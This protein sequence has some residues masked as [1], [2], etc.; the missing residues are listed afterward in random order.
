MY[1]ENLITYFK[2]SVKSKKNV[3]ST[4]SSNEYLVNENLEGNRGCEIRRETNCTKCG[5][6]LLN[7]FYLIIALLM[8]AAGVTV[9]CE[10]LLHDLKFEFTLVSV[11]W[12]ISGVVLFSVSIFGFIAA[13]KNS[14]VW[15]TNYGILMMLAFAIQSAVVIIGFTLIS[16]SNSIASHTLERLV[17]SSQSDEPCGFAIDFIQTSLQCCGVEGA[18]DWENNWKYNSFNNYYSYNDYYGRVSSVRAYRT[19]KSCCSPGSGYQNLRCDNYF[20][21]GCLD[22]TLDLTLQIIMMINY[23][24]MSIAIVQIVGIVIAFVVAKMIRNMKS[25]EHYSHNES[26]PSDE[27][28]EDPVHYYTFNYIYLFIYIFLLAFLYFAKMF[29]ENC[30]EKKNIL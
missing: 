30:S 28:A 4:N 14:V 8:L 25:Y 3:I 22:K 11:L 20:Q 15:T 2:H 12:I 16:K 1:K 18:R 7:V 10:Y 13:N 17:K 19:P 29:L 6:I 24:A 9:Q 23:I 26:L 5:L 21:N 27:S